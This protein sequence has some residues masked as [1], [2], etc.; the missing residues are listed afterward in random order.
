VML[1]HENKGSSWDGGGSGRALMGGMVLRW[2]SPRQ[3][4]V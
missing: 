4:A 2:A 1:L 3:W